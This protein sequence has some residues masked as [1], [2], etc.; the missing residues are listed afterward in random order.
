ME[1]L[2]KDWITNGLIDFEYKKYVLL[3]YLQ[4]V[5]GSFD[6]VKLY[7]AL[8]DLLERY[9][10][11]LS[12]QR[13]KN[14]MKS[15]FPKEISRID[16]DQLKILY[17]EVVDDSELMSQ[18]E[19][20]IEYALP[21][22]KDTLEI[23]KEIFEKVE[24]ALKIEP[25]GIMPL[26]MDEGYLM[27]DLG[28]RKLTDIYQYKVSKFSYSGEGY[29]SVYFEFLE[30][31]KRGIGDTYEGLKLQLIKAYKTLPNP[32]TFLINSPQLFPLKETVMP[33]T[34][35]LVLQTVS[36]YQP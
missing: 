33:V 34:K 29:K 31:I 21:R 3:A 13:R 15:G 11:A 12:F 19:E 23:G 27:I 20:I 8:S 7:P 36:T 17:Q 1:K 10:D 14:L 22:M 2:S 4:K 28:N 24:V 35:R 9:Q 25:I 6:E 26:Y 32:A 30:T 16:L 5:Q 18:L